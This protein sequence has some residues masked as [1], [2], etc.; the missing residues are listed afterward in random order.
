MN[1]AK[2]EIEGLSVVL[3]GSLNPM[4]FH[5]K[6]F[7]SVKLL[8]EEDVKDAEV[9]VI[10][11]DVAQFVLGNGVRIVVVHDRMTMS[12]SDMSKKE[13]VYDLIIKTLNV[14]YHTPIKAVGIHH[15]IH[16]RVSERTYYD[17][18]GHT[19]APKELIWNKVLKKAGLER[20]TIRGCDSEDKDESV[21]VH[22]E[23][24]A[25][26][27]QGLFVSSHYEKKLSSSEEY[28]V[29]TAE[30]AGKYIEGSWD[31]ALN[32]CTEVAEMIFAEIKP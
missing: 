4:I 8:T 22:V 3:V 24:S 16:F 30:K 10:T 17:K 20:L 23:S 32:K 11:G 7:Q 27:S 18:I 15:N 14:L 28:V 12:V 2:I 26:V 13:F 1:K 31:R 19:L 29:E 9:S 6:W 21:R 25:K 5:P